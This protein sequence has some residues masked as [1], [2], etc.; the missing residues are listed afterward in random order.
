M[1]IL[2]KNAYILT[3]SASDEI[4]ESGCV[5]I[6]GE[7][8]V[9]VGEK[10]NLPETHADRVIEA[11]GNIIMPGFVN[12]HTHLPMTIFKG[13]GE[14][15]PLDRWLNEKI[16]PAEDRLTPEI[17]YW[18]SLLG[19]IEMV[20]SGTTAFLDMYM[21][22]DGFA[23]AVKASRMR[24]TFTR[25]IV[26][27][28]DGSGDRLE[29]SEALY[30]K[31]HGVGNLSVMM[32]LHGEY[33]CTE[34]TARKVVDMAKD[35]GTGIHV[36][37]SETR[38]EHEGA[39]QRHGLTPFGFLNKVGAAD[40]PLAA[41]HCVHVTDKDIARMAEKNVSVL[42]CPQSNLKL[43]SGIAP[44]AKMLAAGVNVAVGTDGSS[45]NNNLDMIE[46]TMLVS[47]LQRGV[48]QNASA[49]SDMQ[50]LKMA[51]CGGA[52]ALGKAGEIGQIQPGFLAD[53][54]MID[55]TG[56]AFT[57]KNDWISC[58]LNSG[59]GRDVAMTMIGGEIVFENGNVNFA[60]EAQTKEKVN[61]FAKQICL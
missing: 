50:A 11:C 36:H 21:G 14:G 7:K 30:R 42:S 47:L 49:V 8:I 60:D 29:D 1:T 6:E 16:W 44:V 57:P 52:K 59:N 46:E 32:S 4:I 15:L 20:K 45:S 5:L 56:I 26:D 28:G 33:T 37:V 54:I 38:A 13:Y 34:S 24:A 43:G 19:L 25:A 22:Y 61:N 3:M 35:F 51:T 41:A 10:E 17:S 23:D 12:A 31:Y 48:S 27:F 2:I 53:I 58:I 39:V 40:V 55:T 9:F 18:S